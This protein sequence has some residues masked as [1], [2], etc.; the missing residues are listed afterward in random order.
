MLNDVAFFKFPKLFFLQMPGALFLS[1]LSLLTTSASLPQQNSYHS[2]GLCLHT[3]HFIKKPFLIHSLPTTS[4]TRVQRR[5]LLCI[6]ICN[7][8]HSAWVIKNAP[9]LFVEWMFKESLIFEGTILPQE[10]SPINT[11]AFWIIIWGQKIIKTFVFHTEINSINV[12]SI[13]TY[14]LSNHLSISKHQKRIFH[15]NRQIISQLKVI[16]SWS[17]EN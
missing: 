14:L 15:F 4:I 8:R 13:L 5:C 11:F 12:I 16:N 2:A 17:L 6:H 10:Q 3:H 9:S 1:Q 7:A